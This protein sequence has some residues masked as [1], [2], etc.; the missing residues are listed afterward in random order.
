[1]TTD[2]TKLETDGLDIPC[3]GEVYCHTGS[4]KRVRILAAEADV[5]YEVLLTRDGRIPQRPSFGSCVTTK[6]VVE[7]RLAEK[8]KRDYA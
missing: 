6:F 4:N 3:K 5:L 7:Y 2:W 1:M 8:T